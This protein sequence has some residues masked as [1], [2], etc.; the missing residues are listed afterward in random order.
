MIKSKV[1]EQAINLL[2]DTIEDMVIEMEQKDNQIDFLEN[3]IGLPDSKVFE[4]KN[5]LG[6]N[7]KS[8]KT[9]GGRI[10]NRLIFSSNNR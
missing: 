10:M 1:F 4:E 2:G 7:E 5:K 8:S 6:L 9:K 3:K